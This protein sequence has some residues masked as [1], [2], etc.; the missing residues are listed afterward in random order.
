MVVT[1]SAW[2]L[3]RLIEMRTMLEVSCARRAA[4]HR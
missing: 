2:E 1:I 3:A 4:D